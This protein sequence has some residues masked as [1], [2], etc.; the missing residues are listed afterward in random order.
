MSIFARRRL[1]D[2]LLAEAFELPSRQPSV[3]PHLATQELQ[4]YQRR[5]SLS[6]APATPRNLCKVRRSAS[7]KEIQNQSLTRTALNPQSGEVERQKG[8]EREF[9][10]LTAS[11]QWGGLRAKPAVIGDFGSAKSSGEYWV[12]KNWRRE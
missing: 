12:Q 1:F 5:V 9:R 8:R 6:V 4:R 10:A 2:A 3:T 11:R 7:R